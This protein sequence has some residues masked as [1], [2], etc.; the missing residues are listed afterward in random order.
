[1]AM[2]VTG[3]PGASGVPV[4]IF[5][6]LIFQSA[7]QALGKRDKYRPNVFRVARANHHSLALD[8]HDA[9][10]TLRSVPGI[11]IPQKTAQ[12]TKCVS[13]FRL[14]RVRTSRWWQPHQRRSASSSSLAMTLKYRQ[15]PAK[16]PPTLT[17][18]TARPARAS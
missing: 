13:V 3:A 6:A 10:S 11:F 9:T 14:S 1:W 18:S 16:T 7:R 15:V 4:A 8:D 17:P 2:S 12:E 5:L